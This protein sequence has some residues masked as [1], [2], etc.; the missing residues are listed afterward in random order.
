MAYGNSTEF[1]KKNPEKYALRKLQIKERQKEIRQQVQEYKKT[2]A[3]V[4]CGFSHP[5]AIDFHHRDP[6]NKTIEISLIWRKGWS[7]A[8]IQTELDKCD[9]LC[10]NCHAILHAEEREL[11]G[12]V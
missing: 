8:K 12:M 10:R 9:A 3:C 4:R 5:A 6:K 11:A 7:W 2:V 1:Y